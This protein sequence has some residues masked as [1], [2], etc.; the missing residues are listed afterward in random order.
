MGPTANE[1][2]FCHAHEMSL[3]IELHWCCEPSFDNM[4]VSEERLLHA[5]KS[6][7]CQ[8]QVSELGLLEIPVAQS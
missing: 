7:K 5:L 6:L 2:A 4:K 8:F 3:K 1:K